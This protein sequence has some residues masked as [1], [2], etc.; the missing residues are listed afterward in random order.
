MPYRAEFIKTGPHFRNLHLY[1]N[2]KSRIRYKEIS[3]Q[4][5]S[6]TIRSERSDKLANLNS[7][8]SKLTCESLYLHRPLREEKTQIL[9]QSDTDHCGTNSGIHACSSTVRPHCFEHRIKCPK[10]FQRDHVQYNKLLNEFEA[11]MLIKEGPHQNFAQKQWCQVG[12][13]ML[14]CLDLPVRSP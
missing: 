13:S 12:K 4:C 7:Q 6:S 1:M 8:T 3:V 11:A 10:L 9:P 2:T 5:P 14:G